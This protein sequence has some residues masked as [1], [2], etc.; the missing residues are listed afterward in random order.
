MDRSRKKEIA[1]KNDAV[2][3]KKWRGQTE[4]KAPETIKG[5]Y[6]F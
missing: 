2:R 4:T 5:S 1:D 3:L 6:I